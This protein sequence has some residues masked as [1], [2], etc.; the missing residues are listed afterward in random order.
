MKIF[1]SRFF[2]GIILVFF[3]LSIACAEIKAESAGFIF[4]L[5]TYLRNDLIS[6]NNVVDLDSSNHDDHTVYFGVD[7]SLGFGV[8][9]KDE[10][11]VKSYL[12][13]ERN[14]PYD[15]N[16]PLFVHNTLMNT[17]GVIEK[18]RGDELLPEVEEFWLDYLLGDFCRM[19]SGL[20]TYTV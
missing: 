5:D 9:Q 20:Y 10:D 8:K 2:L 13:L 4:S 6:W 18:Y 16:A 19:K 14:G 17:G 12:K 3:F 7:Y 1:L 11:G 15:Y